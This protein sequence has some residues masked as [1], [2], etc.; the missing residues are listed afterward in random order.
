[1]SKKSK[2]FRS[3]KQKMHLPR[4]SARTWRGS[5]CS[6]WPR[7]TAARRAAGSQARARARGWGP[8]FA[9]GA[10][11]ADHVAL[12]AN[13]T[14]WEAGAQGGL[15]VRQP[16]QRAIGARAFAKA[17]RQRRT[18]RCFQARRRGYCAHG[19]QSRRDQC[20]CQSADGVPTRARVDHS[21]AARA[22]RNRYWA[23]LFGRVRVGQ[24][25]G[26]K[27]THGA[28]KRGCAPGSARRV[29]GRQFARHP[30]ADFARPR[31][32]SR[33]VFAVGE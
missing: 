15:P 28:R 10:A 1:M 11:C 31:G 3:E 12:L 2:K 5:R 23:L 18:A 20:E 29:R 30:A 16:A 27:H 9:L 33:N 25:R 17:A 14:Q 13:A 21:A 4:K 24:R 8:D 26:R 22:R 32:S 7:G 19:A 6:F